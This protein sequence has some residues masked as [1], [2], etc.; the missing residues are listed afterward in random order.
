M[1]CFTHVEAS[2]LGAAVDLAAVR[3]EELRAAARVRAR[4]QLGPLA[5]VWRRRAV[6]DGNFVGREPP[7]IDVEFEVDRVNA[8]A[9][10]ARE[11]SVSP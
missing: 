10:T 1:F 2:T 6:E 7:E 9:A 8:L 11:T 3:A 5:L 4:R